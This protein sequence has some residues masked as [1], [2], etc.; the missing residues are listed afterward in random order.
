METP[1]QTRR[2]QRSMEDA[3]QVMAAYQRWFQ[4]QL[5]QGYTREQI[6]QMLN[7]FDTSEEEDHEPN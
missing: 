7:D 3:A 6:I 5:D 2:R 4:H 1:A